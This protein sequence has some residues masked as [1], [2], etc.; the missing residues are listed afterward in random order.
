MLQALF[1]EL[2]ARFQADNLY[3]EDPIDEAFI[4][5]A[6]EPGRT[7]N[8]REWMAEHRRR[9]PPVSPAPE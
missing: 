5:G 9:Y 6:E 7:W 8:M 2:L 1:A 4:R 3:G